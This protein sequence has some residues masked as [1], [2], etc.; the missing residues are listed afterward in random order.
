MTP[1]S[2]ALIDRLKKSIEANGNKKE[3]LLY[4]EKQ[5][6]LFKNKDGS[7]HVRQKR[8]QREE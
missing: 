3:S 1:S 2:K 7:L 6:G 5:L 8:N 4:A